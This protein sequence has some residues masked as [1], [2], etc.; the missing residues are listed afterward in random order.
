MDLMIGRM[1]SEV[2]MGGMKVLWVDEGIGEEWWV[3]VGEW[4]RR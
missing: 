4:G 2:G 3:G 1:M